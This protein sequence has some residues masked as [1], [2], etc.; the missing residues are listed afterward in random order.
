MYN[1]PLGPTYAGAGIISATAWQFGG[2]QWL[3]M[4]LAIFTLIGAGWALLRTGPAAV[5]EGPR[6]AVLALGRR[7]S[8]RS[9]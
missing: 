5:T 8:R 1:N 3:L 6:K 4:M 9:V 2:V 7:I